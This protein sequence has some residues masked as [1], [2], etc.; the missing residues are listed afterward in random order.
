MNAVRLTLLASHQDSYL[1]FV[2]ALKRRLL[3]GRVVSRVRLEK[4]SVEKSTE[5][6][7]KFIDIVDHLWPPKRNDIDPA[8]DGE[9]RDGSNK[10]VDMM[11]SYGLRPQQ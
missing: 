6:S 9:H 3:A 10:N 1:R 8:D 7:H 4:A 2:E 11:P 5:G